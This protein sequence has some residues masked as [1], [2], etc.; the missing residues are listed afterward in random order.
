M[1]TGGLRRRH[2]SSRLLCSTTSAALNIIRRIVR[3]FRL[4]RLSIAFA[5][6]LSAL[7][8][9]I[10]CRLVRQYARF[11]ARHAIVFA[12]MVATHI[13]LFRVLLDF[14]APDVLRFRHW[15]ILLPVRRL[16]GN[17]YKAEDSTAALLKKPSLA[18][19][20]RPV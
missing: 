20:R 1:Y 10:L 3:L 14:L 19:D 18:Q 8:L 7:G 13:L 16:V 5:P 11:D 9:G 4:T 17:P 6:A 15:R 2:L 12:T